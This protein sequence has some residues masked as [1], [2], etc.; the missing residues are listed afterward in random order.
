MS[1]KK[2]RVRVYTDGQAVAFDDGLKNVVANLGTGRDKSSHSH[3]FVNQLSSHDL[4]TIYRTSWLAKR[5]VRTPARDATRN[6]RNWRA[7]A[8]QIS[9][10]EAEEAR[11][12]LQKKTL[13]ALI[14]S[15]LYGGSAIY[16]NTGAVNPAAPLGKSEQ[17]LSLVVLTKDALTANEINK[18]INSEYYGRSETYSLRSN[19]QPVTIHASRFALFAGEGIPGDASTMFGG[20]GDSVLQS[21]IDSVKGADATVA[22]IASLV[23][24]SKVDVLKV[25][26]F[27]QLLADNKDSLILRRAVLQAAMKGN[28]GMLMIDAKDDYEQKSFAFAGLP[29]LWGKFQEWVAGAFEIPVTRLFGRSSAG[30]S[31]SGDG[32]ER[33]YYDGIA[34]D[35]RLVIGPALALLDELIINQALGSRPAEIYY[36]WAPLRQLSESDRAE[37]FSKTATGLRALAGANAGEIIP[38]DALSDSAVNELVELGV[39]PGLEQKII[40]YGTLAEQNGFV[41]GDDE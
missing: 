31:G 36:E 3:Y 34:Q 27:A 37:I 8:D 25:E 24:E 15:R 32:D 22:N 21:A 38:L 28:N 9:K 26:G 5:G 29:D 2:P 19:G 7:E 11:L 40:E 18:D 39:L 16:I 20:W 10:I 13:E 12:G 1:S 14:A 17:V 4:L 6:W 33:V 30:L 23:F 41:G 35:Q